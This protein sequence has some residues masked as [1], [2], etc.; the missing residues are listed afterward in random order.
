MK[1]EEEKKIIQ[2]PITNFIITIQE[3]QNTRT[4]QAI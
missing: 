4:N 2:L 3:K 1:N